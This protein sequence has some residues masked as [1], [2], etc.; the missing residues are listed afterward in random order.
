MVVPRA[1]HLSDFRP[2]V[3]GNFVHLALLCCL[4]WVLGADG[5]E[6]VLCP[7]LEPFVEVGELVT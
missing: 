5:E 2:L 3:L 1:V 7:I 4:I 6:E